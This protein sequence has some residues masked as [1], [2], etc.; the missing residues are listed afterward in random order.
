MIIDYSMSFIYVL[1]H[2]QDH[3]SR[4]FRSFYGLTLNLGWTIL[5]LDWVMPLW[6]WRELPAASVGLRV[7]TWRRTTLLVSPPFVQLTSP[8]SARTR[9]RRGMLWIYDWNGTRLKVSSLASV[10]VIS[11]STLACGCCGCRCEECLF[12]WSQRCP[13]LGY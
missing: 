12:I 4:A 3:I 6:R 5:I 13:A 8:F 1:K 2:A 7:P 11:R 9:P 10:S